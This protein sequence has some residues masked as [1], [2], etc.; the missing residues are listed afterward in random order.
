MGSGPS[1]SVHLCL[2]PLCILVSK[3]T[4]IGQVWVCARERVHV[5]MCMCACVLE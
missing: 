4:D 5:S 1:P 3:A 2:C